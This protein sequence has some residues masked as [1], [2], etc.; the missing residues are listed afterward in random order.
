MENLHRIYP[1]VHLALGVQIGEYVVIGVPPR[2]REPGDLETYIGPNAVIRSHTVIYAGNTIGA[3]FQTGHAVMIREL[4]EIGDGVSIGTHSIIEH[5]VK[6]GNGV[7]VHSN[8]FIPEYSE[9]EAGCWIGPNVVFT[10]ALYPLAPGAKETLAGPV[11]RPGAKIGANATLLPGI[12]VGENALVGA[13]AVVVRDVPDG[14]V[15][16]GNPARVIKDVADLGVY[17][18]EQLLQKNTVQAHGAEYKGRRCGSIG[19]LA[20]FSFYPGK[21]L[22]AYG[23]AGMVT[24]NDE[25][26]LAKVRRLRNHGRTSKY[27]HQEVGWGERLDALQAAILGAKLAHLEAWTEARRAHARRYTELLAACD[28]V[29]P[30]EA[31]CVRH[32][33]HLYVIRTPRRDDLLAHLRARGIGAGVHYPIPLHRQPAYRREGYGDVHLPITEQVAAE[34]LSLPMYPELTETRIAYIAEAVKEFLART[35]DA[36][37]AVT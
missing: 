37:G 6:I 28:V 17:P 1:N 14:K 29:T 34:V 10:N 36:E 19:H 13:G 7:R 26:L 9:L 16:I 27:E 22:G 24:G 8:A 18:S 2:G 23:D 15:V 21:N 4:N 5:H 30:Y 25:E 3:N 32:V 11:I 33:Y 20:C 12:V 35:L 31:S